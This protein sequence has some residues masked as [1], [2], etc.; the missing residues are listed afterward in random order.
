MVYE[1]PGVIAAL[2]LH[3]FFVKACVH[4]KIKI[5][6]SNKICMLFL[7]LITLSFVSVIFR[8]LEL[9][10]SRRES[11]SFP[12][13]STWPL[14]TVMCSAQVWWTNWRLHNKYQ[15]SRRRETPVAQ[16]SHNQPDVQDAAM[17][18]VNSTELRKQQCG[19]Q[20]TLACHYVSWEQMYNHQG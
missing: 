20:E 3:F 17:Q 6:T 11:L 1:T 19:W 18:K 4:V 5:S 14:M 2:G 13:L 16:G 10:L 9:N 15:M 8:A 7:L 12:T